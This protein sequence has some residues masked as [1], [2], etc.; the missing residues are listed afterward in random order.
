M[1]K[2]IL[3][4]QLDG[5]NN[6]N[7]SRFH[8]P[9]HKGRGEDFNIFN[10]DITEIPGADN[11][12]DA[13][14]IIA[15]VQQKLA[16][17]YGS[18]EAAMLVNGTTTGIH[19]A[20]L[21]ACCPGDK[22]IIPTNCH[23]SVFGALALGRI[24]GVFITPEFDKLMG[25]AREITL[26]SVKEAIIRYPDSIG[27]VLTNPTYYGT[28]S[29]VKAI[30]GFLH[31]QRKFLIVDEAHG[32]HLHFND[33]LPLDAM[34]AGADIS[35]QSTHKILGS[36]TQSSLIHF[37]GSRINRQRVKSFLALL[38][39]SSPS[40][41]LMISVEEAVDSAYEKG[42]GVFKMIID[43]H[44]NF[45]DKQ[46]S[47]VPI[48]LYAD[49]ASSTGY[50]RSKWLF[51]T[52]GIAGD[53]VEELL[54]KTHG[55]QCE[56]SGNNHVLAMTG[57]GT[58]AADINA[59]IL[60]IADLNK[61]IMSDGF[62]GKATVQDKHRTETVLF[63][64]SIKTEMPL[65]QALYSNEKESIPLAEAVNRLAGDFIIPY[66]PGIPVL[67]PG[68]RIS[69]KIIDGLNQLIDNSVA[70]VGI[71]ENR[72]LLLLKEEGARNEA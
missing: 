55:I 65:W 11:L 56:M 57:M 36:L 71:H 53:Q 39:S 3:K 5:L 46:G 63:K 31:R 37:Q 64:D 22:L 51:H 48:T 10:Y 49:D 16:A 66:P 69:Q 23:R 18:D 30:A 7:H 45:C 19:S 6:Q 33:A 41:P 14:G 42:S 20:I 28:T 34:A 13:Q 4:K 17:I 12:H 59:L 15:Q 1:K 25:F 38:Q 9:G 32:A 61:K 26:A 8:M 72:E 29:D 24:E 21:G 40:Y 60:G 62:S 43:A 52:Q 58:T 50:D 54:S 2:S 68:S 70:V 27:M 47:N 44:Q 67:L 35:I